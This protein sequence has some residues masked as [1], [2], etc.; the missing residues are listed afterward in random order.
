MIP[1]CGFNFCIFLVANV[2]KQLSMHIFALL[3]SLHSFF[4]K[5]SAHVSRPFFHWAV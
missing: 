3:M 4:S 5:M 1:H 2:D